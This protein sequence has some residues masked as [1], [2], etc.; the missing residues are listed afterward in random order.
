MASTQHT[1]R[2]FHSKHKFF[3]KPDQQRLSD[4]LCHSSLA[5]LAGI[6]YTGSMTARA[7]QQTKHLRIGIDIG[8]TFTDFIIYNSQTGEIQSFKVLSTPQDPAIAV[9]AGL[10]RIVQSEQAEIVHGSTVATNALLERRGARTALITTAGFRDV[11][12]IGRQNRPAL[13]DWFAD[14]PPPLIPSELRLEV[15]ERVGHTGEVIRPLDAKQ[16][17]TILPLLKRTGV[18]SVAICLLFSFLHTEHE[19]TLAENLRKEGFFVS[20]SC[21]ILPTYREYERAS[22]TAVN[23]YV[24]PIL[25]RYL[26]RLEKALPQAKLRV[27]QSNGG[28]ISL[29]EAQRSGV[30]C[31]LSGPAG[32][33]AGAQYL[34]QLALPPG[35]PMRLITFDMGGTS[36]D[37]SLV[38]GQPALTNEAVVGGCP[39]A[40]PLLD[41]HTIGAGG[42]SIATVDLGGALRVGPQSAGAD[43]GPACYGRSDLPTVTDANLVLGRLVPEQF[44]GGQM[45]LD[46]ERAYIALERLGKS[47]GLNAVET[48]LGVIEVVNAH[49]ER[50]LRVISVE[51]GHDPRD[52]ILFSFGGA[53]GL[54]AADLAHR[55]GIP[56]LVISPLASTLSAF[57][58]LAAEVIKDYMQT[59]MLPG[60]ATLET[61]R[62]AFQP[63]IVQGL[64]DLRSEGLTKNQIVL[65]PSLD[66]RYV[67]QSYELSVPFKDTLHPADNF[68]AI[69]ERFY[70][71]AQKA[72]PVE[73]VN[74]RLRAIG[75]ISKPRP[76]TSTPSQNVQTQNSA[77]ALLE[78]RPVV[79]SKGAERIPFYQGEALKPG[80]H[81][82]GPAAVVRTDTTILLGHK[83]HAKVDPFLNLWIT[84]SG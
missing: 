81:F 36:T 79:F 2:I 30:R 9:L 84:F 45:P 25:S 42:G 16:I 46:T 53:G 48:A 70:G 24:S 11:L 74:L 39:I 47:L 50:A 31:I 20:P 29:A 17:E 63:L 34:A 56:R 15:D 32:G 59:V 14:P 72:N 10:E 22:T 13:Y 75:T 3:Q 66:M 51:R 7:N 1:K 73:I 60:H 37:V 43:P 82:S 71:Y 52:C 19:K 78:Y 61:I 40:I 28:M 8:G 69:H 12:Q 77:E 57:G 38:E 55:L 35:A 76:R 27:M 44:L 64:D 68:H 65:E 80:D 6:P 33:V 4:F 23:A 83:D 54:H 58:M 21:E 67:G 26:K 62:A 41:I 18:E 5:D 49:M